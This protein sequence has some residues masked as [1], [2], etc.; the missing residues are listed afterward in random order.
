MTTM[1]TDTPAAP[2]APAERAVHLVEPLP[3]FDDERAYRLAGIDDGG[4][5]LSLRS[6]NRPDL[7]FVLT[8]A[9]CFFDDYRPGLTPVIAGSLGAPDLDDLEVLLMLT[10]STGL[11]EATANLRAPIV[12][13]RSTGRAMQVVLDDESLPMRRR[14]VTPTA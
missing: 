1:T 12:V 4:A 5:L 6:V 8:P 10:I 9:D 7:R 11:A 3:G 2:G 13:S 14:L